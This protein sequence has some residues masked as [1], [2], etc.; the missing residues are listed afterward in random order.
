M[1]VERC[2]TTIGSC[3]STLWLT[4][5]RRRRG[6]RRLDMNFIQLIILRARL[7]QAKDRGQRAKTRESAR[8]SAK[9]DET[10]Q[11]VWVHVLGMSS[12]AA[13]RKIEGDITIIDAPLLSVDCHL[14]VAHCRIRNVWPRHAL[15]YNRG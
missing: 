10:A 15:R 5:R 9:P 7:R 14:G 8:K 12:H 3:L 13:P 1:D 2:S 6:R 4:R 11:P